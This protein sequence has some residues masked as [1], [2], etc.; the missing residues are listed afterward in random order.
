M[1]HK[2]SAILYYVLS[3]LDFSTASAALVFMWYKSSVV[4]SDV[5]MAHSALDEAAEC[6]AVCCSESLSKV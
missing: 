6:T 3:G 1:S 2:F 4:F 5:G